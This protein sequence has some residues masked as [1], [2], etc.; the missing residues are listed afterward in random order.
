MNLIPSH[1]LSLR[2]YALLDVVL[3]VA[4]FA[5][6]ATGLMQVMLRVS[7][8]SSG[9]ARDRYVQQQLE[10]L[11][12]EKR[13]LGV[14]AMTSEMVDALTGITFRTFVEPYEVDNGEGSELTN[15]YRLTADATYTDDGGEQVEKAELIIYVPEP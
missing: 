12:A 7:E 15:L 14:E 10:G 13:K 11:L 3:A 1:F 2:G 4:L 6:T 9:F 8:T 5:I